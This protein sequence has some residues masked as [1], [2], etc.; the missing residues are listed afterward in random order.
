MARQKKIFLDEADMPKQWY[1]LAP[2]LPTPLN[3]PLGPDGKPI[4]PDMLA[5]VFPMNLIEQEVSQERWIDIPEEIRQH[6]FRWRPSPLIRAYEL[7][8][9]LGTPAKIYYKNEGV[10]PAGSHK[11]N[12]AIPQAWYNKQFGIK[13]LTTETGAGQ[14]GSALS[15]ACSII[16]GIE[17]KVFMV[18]V[19]FDQK[20]FRKMMMNT[21]GGQCVASPSTETQAGRDILAQFPDTPGS[22]GIA[23]SEA[24]EAAVSD[25]TGQTRYSLGSVLNHVML[26]QSIIGLEAKKQLAKV[27]IDKPDIVIGCCG[28]GSNFAGLS[29][30]FIYDKINGAD[31]QVIGAEPFSCPTLTKAPFIY[32]NGDV[33]QMTPLMAMHSLGHTFVPAPIHA[34]GLRYHGMAPLVSAALR[35]GLMEAQAIHQS[36]CFEAGLLFSKTEGIIPAPETTHAIAA[37]IREARKAKEEGKEKTILFNF[38]GHGLM[39]LVGY[40]KYLGGELHDYEYP[41]AEIALNLEKLKGYPLPK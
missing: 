28:G 3:P 12:T 5:P 23:I 25:T 24:I 30:P 39:D 17:C 32:D 13:K 1:N 33:A 11:P 19:S 31:I 40:D 18:R 7:E 2:D 29:F 20:P 36:E 41:D 9:A 22:L 15:F 34:G 10:S 4:S 21:W 14:W 26:H 16:G 37:T 6:L 8:E 35:D 38:S 27:G